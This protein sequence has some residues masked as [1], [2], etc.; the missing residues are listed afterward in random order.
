MRAP[1][2]ARMPRHRAPAIRRPAA[3]QPVRGSRPARCGWRVP[4]LD[5]FDRAKRRFA[6]LA[7]AMRST[8]HT[9]PI[10]IQMARRAGPYISSSTGLTVTPSV[11]E[12]GGSVDAI[13]DESTFNSASTR[14]GV[15]PGCRR[16]TARNTRKRACFSTDGQEARSGS[17][18][19]TSRG[20]SKMRDATPIT[21]A[22]SF[23]P[24]SAV[25][26]ISGAP[27]NR[28]RH[29]RWLITT[30]MGAFGTSSLSSMSRPLGG[31]AP[32]TRKKLPLTVV[33]STC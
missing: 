9:A 24:V 15:T 31:R 13:C 2:R 27:P 4:A 6:T 7:Q 23:P 21:V 25:L 14:S 16:A 8:K 32:S 22:V 28:G 33:P 29:R 10:S 19:S 30:R 12:P 5:R 17:Q 11:S 20:K 26:L 1:V 3:S 18:M